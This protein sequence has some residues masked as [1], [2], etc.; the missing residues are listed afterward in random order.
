MESPINFLSNNLTKRGSFFISQQINFEQLHHP[1][2]E[3]LYNMNYNDKYIYNEMKK[4]KGY[5]LKEYIVSNKM[6][7]IEKVMIA[8]DLARVIDFLHQRNIA[9][10]DIKSNNVLYMKN[11]QTKLIVY[12]DVAMRVRSK[13]LKIIGEK[14][15]STIHYDVWSYGLLLD[16]LFSKVD[17]NL[18]YNRKKNLFLWSPYLYRQYPF[19]VSKTIQNKKIVNLIEKLTIHNDD[20]CKFTVKHATSILNRVFYEEVVKLKKEKPPYQFSTIEKEIDDDEA[21]LIE[22]NGIYVLKRADIVNIVNE[23]NRYLLLSRIKEYLI[24]LKG[25]LSKGIEKVAMVTSLINSSLQEFYLNNTIPEDIAERKRFIRQVSHFYSQKCLLD[26][27]FKIKLT[28][29]MVKKFSK[30]MNV[31]KFPLTLIQMD[32]SHPNYDLGDGGQAKIKRAKIFA[33]DVAVKI[34]QEFNMENFIK[35]VNIFKKFYHSFIPIVYGIYEHENKEKHKVSIN[36]AMELVNGDT[37]EK[38]MLLKKYCEL[39]KILILLDLALVLEYIH[40]FGM[41]HRDL[42]PANVMINKKLDVKLIDFGIAR[43]TKNDTSGFTPTRVMGTCIYMA[44]EN[45][46]KEDNDDLHGFSESESESGSQQSDS[47]S[48]TNSDIINFN[49][50]DKPNPKI[51][52]KVDVWAYGLIFNELLTGDKSYWF[53]KKTNDIQIEL[54]LL[55]KK[56]Y[57]ISKKINNEYIKRVLEGCMKVNPDERFDMKTVKELTLALLYNKIKEITDRDLY[58]YYKMNEDKERE[59]DR[60]RGSAS[61]LNSIFDFDKRFY[62]FSSK[63]QN[64]LR[65]FH[66]TL[67]KRN[68]IPITKNINDNVTN[69]IIKHETEVAKHK[70]R[71]KTVRISIIN[72]NGILKSKSIRQS[73]EFSKQKTFIKQSSV[74]K[75]FFKTKTQNREFFKNILGSS[76]DLKRLNKSNKF[77]KTITR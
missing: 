75:V 6:K 43:T 37:L 15:P 40:G 54:N 16:E 55:D 59:K 9:H 11:K 69:A 70:T 19:Q 27:F 47:K 17:D 46:E 62:Y 63:I 42:K 26:D 64:Y 29:E 67:E 58:N 38:G 5:S 72:K 60:E 66:F 53:M 68:G 49:D 61:N 18:N 28:N 7:E 30:R 77:T 8:L 32:K 48:V 57:H 41:I 74:Q 31:A 2:A 24:I 10:R 36:I 76:P 23:K 71:Q 20:D 25:F 45:Y 39:E 52:T 33:Q 50:G 34:L 4:M 51:S 1:N 12:D 3:V 22:D 65:L 73:A 56:E 44:P 21:D 13:G 35:E 14:Y